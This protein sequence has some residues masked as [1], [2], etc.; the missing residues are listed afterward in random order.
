M[1]EDQWRKIKG[2]DTDGHGEKPDSR[3]CCQATIHQDPQHTR[4]ET[5]L[6]DAARR[7][8][9]RAR[10]ARGPIRVNPA[11][12]RANP[13]R[14][15]CAVVVQAVV[16][17]AAVAVAVRRVV[18]IRCSSAA[19]IPLRPSVP[20]GP[21]RSPRAAVRSRPC[22]TPGAA[23]SRSPRCRADE[24]CVAPTRSPLPS[25]APG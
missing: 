18:A 6:V 15:S 3:G 25:T 24:E 16:V 20:C 5:S 13:C 4:R 9:W 21:P 14:G 1:A 2:F 17:Q 19:G 22:R 8:I 23:R 12:L 10:P 11:A 7:W